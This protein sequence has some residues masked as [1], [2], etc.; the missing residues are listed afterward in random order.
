MTG[1]GVGKDDGLLECG[2]DG[3]ELLVTVGDDVGFLDG[4]GVTGEAEG[5]CV[6]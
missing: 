4:P 6:G 5:L 2:T 1:E 3:L